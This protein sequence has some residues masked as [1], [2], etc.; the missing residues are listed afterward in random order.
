MAACTSRVRN[1][2]LA[3]TTPATAATASPVPT[4]SLRDPQPTPRPGAPRAEQAEPRHHLGVAPFLK[5]DHPLGVVAVGGLVENVP[6]DRA[7]RVGRQYEP[8]PPPTR[9]RPRLLPGEL[10]GVGRR[11]HARPRLRL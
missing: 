6:A 2:W 4:H 7:T 9:H 8:R 11:V 5:P 1:H 3:R 10:R